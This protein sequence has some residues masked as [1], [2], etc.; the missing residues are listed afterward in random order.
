L[1]AFPN[2]E[3][4]SPDAFV[5][6][7]SQVFTTNT[8]HH[9]ALTRSGNTFT[10][11]VDGTNRGSV[12]TSR[13]LTSK[14]YNFIL[15]NFQRLIP[16]DVYVQDL[17]LY[18]GVAKYTSNFN[19]VNISSIMESIDKQLGQF[20]TDASGRILILSCATAGKDPRTLT[21]VPGIVLPGTDTCIDDERW[22]NFLNLARTVDG[23]RLAPTLDNST[24]AVINPTTNNIR[25]MINANILTLRSSLTDFDAINGNL[26]W[27]E[28]SGADITGLDYSLLNWTP[29][30][31]FGY[32]GQ[33]N[34]PFFD[35]YSYSNTTANWW[36]LPPGVPNFSGA[37]A[38]PVATAPTPAPAPSNPCPKDNNGRCGRLYRYK[39]SGNPT[40]AAANGT[41]T[42]NVSGSFGGYNLFNYGSVPSSFSVDVYISDE[43]YYAL[44]TSNVFYDGR[45]LIDDCSC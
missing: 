18:K 42:P 23:Y 38:A 40:G 10:I 5:E 12:T 36:I 43:V 26:A 31:S 11:W 1:L 41:L 22:Q 28:T 27:D 21:K 15:P 14:S 4:G 20:Y 9:I 13:D 37:P 7:S 25:R 34:N 45:E 16:D 8:W 32:Y 19:T 39:F 29:S 24:T 30:Y 2:I 35:G 17:R 44:N 6:T 33:S 3:T